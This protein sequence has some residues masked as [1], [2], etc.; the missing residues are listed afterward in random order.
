M[1]DILKMKKLK[2]SI[3]RAG[4]IFTLFFTDRQ[5]CDYAGAKTCDTRKYARF[6]WS[7]LEHGVNLP[8]SQFEGNFISFAHQKRDLEFMLETFA[9]NI[10]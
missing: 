8:P 6:F 2:F 4:S 3:N 9:E 10:K 1:E 7:M 5:V